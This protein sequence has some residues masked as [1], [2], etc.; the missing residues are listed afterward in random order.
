M[1]RK[2][3]MDLVERLKRNQTEKVENGIK[4]TYKPIPDDDREGVLDPRIYKSMRVPMMLMKFMPRKKQ[5]PLDSVL[6]MRPMFN[7]VTSIPMT[8]PDTKIEHFSVK[9]DG[10]KVPIRL[11]TPKALEPGQ[12]LPVLYYIHGGGFFAGSPDV[13]EE[14]CKFFAETY[15][16]IVVSV[17]YRLAPENPYPAGHNDCYAALEWVYQ[18]IENH[19]GDKEKIFVS[20]DSAGGNLATYCGM[21]DKEDKTGMVKALALYYPTVNMLGKEDEYFKAGRQNYNVIKK[22]G[23]VVFGML[24]MMGSSNPD[25]NIL[26]LVLGKDIDMSHHYLSPYWGN[27]EGL[28]P[29]LLLFGEYDFLFPECKAFAKKLDNANVTSKTIIY[30]GMTHAFLDNMGKQPQAEDS[31]L[32]VI[33]FVKKYI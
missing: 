24:D 4:I 15:P 7:G 33:D 32:E 1:A 8:N 21:K 22:H 17:E 23:K 26:N 6:S 16:C 12:K 28:P 31:V 10:V 20:G 3:S 18:N 27:L 19:G 13:V 9:N 29:T 25:E 5:S 11:Y 14:A 2:Y 30:K